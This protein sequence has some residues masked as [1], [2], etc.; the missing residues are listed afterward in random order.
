MQFES[1]PD[2]EMQE[3]ADGWWVRELGAGRA[4][5]HGAGLR[6]EARH[7]R[8]AAGDAATSL[9]RSWSVGADV[10]GD[11]S[12]AGGRNWENQSLFAREK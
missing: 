9:R 7:G 12:A 10:S 4:A 6:A 2:P 11:A 3:G 1:K 8:A 5:A